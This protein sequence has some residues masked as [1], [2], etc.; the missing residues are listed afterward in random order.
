MCLDVYS[1]SPQAYK[2]MANSE[3]FEA[4]PTERLLR[5][6]KNCV[7]QSTGLITDN[8][9][10]LM[11]EADKLGF[12]FDSPERVGGLSIDEVSIQVLVLSIK[13]KR[14]TLVK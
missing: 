2:A 12:E 8:L 3:I 14:S 10:W 6:Y 5:L 4:L 1:R 9:R 11:A 7:R 13:F